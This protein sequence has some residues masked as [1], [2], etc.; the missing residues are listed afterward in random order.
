MVENFRFAG[1]PDC[2]D[3]HRTG[4]L[5]HGKATARRQRLL[6]LHTTAR[7]P[8][9][10]HLNEDG[11]RQIDQGQVLDGALAD[12]VKLRRLPARSKT[13]DLAVAGFARHPKFRGLGSLV[14]LVPP[15]PVAQPVQDPGELGAG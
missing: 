1:K 8:A 9:P 5:L 11:D 12:V 13:L 4:A 6:P 3:S 2:R 15:D 14:I 7:A 10:L